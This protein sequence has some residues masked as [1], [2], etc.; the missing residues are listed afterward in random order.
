MSKLRELE[1]HIQALNNLLLEQQDQIN[2]IAYEKDKY[3]KSYIELNLYLKKAWFKAARSYVTFKNLNTNNV[4]V[5]K[6]VA[7]GLAIALEALQ[8]IR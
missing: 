6:G 8:K 5:E 2:A 1:L 3:K 7:I 4:K